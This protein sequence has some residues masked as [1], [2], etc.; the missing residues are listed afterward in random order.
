MAS[1]GNG[2]PEYEPCYTGFASS[3]IEKVAGQFPHISFTVFETV[4]MNDFLNHLI[5]QDTVFIQCEKDAGVFV[6]RFL[7]DEGFTNVMYKPS[8][9]E[10]GLYW[11]KNQVIV[12]DMVSEAPLSTS[13]P[14][15]I[16]LEK[17]LVDM[18]CDKLIRDTYSRAEY[19]SVVEQAVKTYRLDR[20]KMLRYARRRNKDREISQFLQ[21]L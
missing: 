1:C 7:Q 11:S 21:D 16:T 2:L 6:F 20:P 18:Y 17:M 15:A 9:K 13:S 19:P 10:L 14:H 3:L 5:A 4:L 12:T 8:K